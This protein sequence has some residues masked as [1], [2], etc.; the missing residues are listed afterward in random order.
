LAAAMWIALRPTTPLSSGIRWLNFSPQALAQA[1]SEGRPAVV[2]FRA[3][4]CLPCLEMEKT[5]FVSP[6]VATRAGAFTML[7]A[8]VTDASKAA[9][10]LLSSYGVL[11]VPT[12]LFF[13][14]DGTEQ[15]RMVGYV[16]PEEFARMLDDTRGAEGPTRARAE[17]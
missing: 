4:W 8:D 17:S 2:D 9:A 13:S 14:P 1:R 16:S 10:A 3:D 12:T 15:H 7:S 6:A 11:G 5:T